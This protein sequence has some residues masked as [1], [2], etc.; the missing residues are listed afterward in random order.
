MK[1]KEIKLKT[2]VS[3]EDLKEKAEAFVIEAALESISGPEKA[4]IVVNKLVKYLDDAIDYGGGPIG[5]AL[6][7]FDAP[8]MRFLLHLV[9]KQ[10]YEQLREKKYIT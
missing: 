5:K 1:F 3:L 10:A 8:V 9:I 6:D 4:E 7:H 2:S